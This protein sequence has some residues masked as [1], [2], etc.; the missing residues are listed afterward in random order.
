MSIPLSNRE[1]LKVL[2]SEEDPSLTSGCKIREYILKTIPKNDK[3]Q[4]SILRKLDLNS[5]M[6]EIVTLC[7]TQDINTIKYESDKQKITEKCS[8]S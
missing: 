5:T 2:E 4:M 1:V 3:Y 6:E 7:N 8:Q